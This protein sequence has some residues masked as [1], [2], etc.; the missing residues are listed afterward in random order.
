MS[1]IHRYR[2]LKSIT[3]L[4]NRP[5]HSPR[6]NTI[7]LALGHRFLSSFM[8]R[9]PNPDLFRH[10]PGKCL[11]YKFPWSIAYNQVQNRIKCFIF[12]SENAKPFPLPFIKLFE[13]P[14]KSSANNCKQYR[15]LIQEG[16]KRS[17]KQ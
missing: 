8:M 11:N 1:T 4:V 5:M 17:Y 13:F 10:L 12:F 15:K 14:G 6:D 2:S 9:F 3:S 7:M 16:S